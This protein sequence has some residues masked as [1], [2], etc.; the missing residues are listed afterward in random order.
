MLS[1][2]GTLALAC[3]D[4]VQQAVM[5]GRSVEFADVVASAA[6]ATLAAG[7]ILVHRNARLAA[8]LTASAALGAGLVTYQ[9]YATTKD[10]KSGLR[11]AAE[12][13]HAEATTAFRRALDGD[14]E[15]AELLNTLAWSILQVGEERAEDAVRFAR[16]SLDLRPNDADTLDT[17]GWALHK[18][19]R[20]VDARVPLEQALARDPDIYCIHYHLG[21]TY[22]RLGDRA[23][24][25]RH[26]RSQID[27]FPD[28]AE[29]AQAAE[30]L[31]V[32]EGGQ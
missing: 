3:F 17:Y 10:Y 25:E 14:A 19:G 24:A 13:R 2:V 8:A 12:G 21:A 5:P 28:A 31:R 11:L 7:S 1:A 18:A 16:R 23:A 26:L 4:E 32:L 30:A 15:N 6:G 20:F 9:S 29:A 22:L 27:Q